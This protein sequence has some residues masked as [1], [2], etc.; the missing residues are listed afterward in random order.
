[1]GDLLELNS[2]CPLSRQDKA[3]NAYTGKL[4]EI[5]ALCGNAYQVVYWLTEECRNQGLA[6]YGSQAVGLEEAI[7]EAEY[8]VED[9]GCADV[10]VRFS[11]EHSPFGEQAVFFYG[12]ERGGA[13]YVKEWLFPPPPHQKKWFEAC[14]SFFTSRKSKPLFI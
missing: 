1:M 6:S 4:A 5:I 8:A 11:L 7:R 13:A 2:D 9:Y 10:E 3:M 14:C 12:T